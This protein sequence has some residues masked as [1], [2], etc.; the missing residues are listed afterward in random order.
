MAQVVSGIALGDAVITSGGY[1]L[2]DGTNIK[3]EKPSASGKEA[4]TGKE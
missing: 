1:A 3:I 4:G 2:P